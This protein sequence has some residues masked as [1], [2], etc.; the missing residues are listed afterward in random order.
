MIDWDSIVDEQ[1]GTD[2]S[3]CL[4]TLG[5]ELKKSYLQLQVG[6]P[7]AGT[8]AEGVYHEI[9]TESVES[10]ARESA[11]AL[12]DLY[13]AMHMPRR[14]DNSDVGLAF[15]TN[16]L[17]HFRDA[18]C[19]ELWESKDLAISGRDLV[20]VLVPTIVSLLN[21]P[22]PY[23]SLCIPLSVVLSKIGLRAV[24]GEYESRAKSKEFVEKRLELHRKNVL[25]L[26]EQAS[27]YSVGRCPKSL[28]ES[29]SR[30]QSTV[31]RL[32][33]ELGS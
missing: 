3:D 26:E 1:K 21:L 24:C 9:L 2:A 23:I 13:R 29:I 27:R 22:K 31:N 28:R 12:D 16:F 10:A 4:V 6:S 18:I 15:C 7:S 14:N 30:E 11:G 25:F 8:L 32:K 20:V 33:R 19:A 5:C 17:K